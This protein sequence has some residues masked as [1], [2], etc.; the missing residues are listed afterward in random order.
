VELWGPPHV[1]GPILPSKPQIQNTHEIFWLFEPKHLN[2]DVW[3]FEIGAM[4]E[5]W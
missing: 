5:L 1:G 2:L 3:W 4:V